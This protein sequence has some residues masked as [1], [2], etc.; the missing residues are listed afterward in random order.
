[1][2]KIARARKWWITTGTAIGFAVAVQTVRASDEHAQQKAAE[3]LIKAFVGICVQTVPNLDRVDAAARLAAW[4]EIKGDAAKMIA[5]QDPA[6]D[7]RGW[8][9]ENEANVPFFVAVSESAPPGRHIAVCS[10][11]NPFAPMLPVRRALEKFL[12]LN[13]PI[14]QD[15]S[16]GQ[17]NIVWSTSSGTADVLISLL[18]ASPMNEDGI[19]LSATVI[20][21]RAR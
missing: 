7:F 17:Q 3:S 1:M 10:V 16:G 15:V 8:L 2:K 4:K 20:E 6:A 14:S 13:A 19:T 21:H 18:A 5:P 9:V 11:G 12:G